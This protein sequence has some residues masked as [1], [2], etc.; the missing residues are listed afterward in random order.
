M[1]TETSCRVGAADVAE[2]EPKTGVERPE[3]RA[4]PNPGRE[5][6]GV[7]EDEGLADGGERRTRTSKSA[8]LD[9]S[10]IVTSGDTGN[11]RFVFDHDLRSECEGSKFTSYPA[12]TNFPSGGTKLS[13]PG[14]SFHRA[15][16]TQG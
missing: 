10:D 9:P 14:F 11:W 15:N 12:S 6:K 4:E 7:T 2:P 3:A 1:V 8:P 16:L 5:A 13:S